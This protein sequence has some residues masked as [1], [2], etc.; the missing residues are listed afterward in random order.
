LKIR[1][2]QPEQRA[3]EAAGRREREGEALRKRGDT[4][5]ARE[6][7]QRERKF[8]VYSDF[9]FSVFHLDLFLSSSFF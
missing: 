2:R 7:R 5:R 8:F 4:S 1:E 9:F 6:K 3:T